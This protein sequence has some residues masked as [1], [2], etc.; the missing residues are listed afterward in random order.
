[1]LPDA[2]A[3]A[4]A[5]VEDAAVLQLCLDW[6]SLRDRSSK[7][8]RIAIIYVDAVKLQIESTT[9]SSHLRCTQCPSS[10]EGGGRVT[11]AVVSATPERDDVDKEA[12]D[13]YC[14]AVIETIQTNYAVKFMQLVDA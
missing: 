2:A 14:C 12:L 1:M 8:D 6:Q 13:V 10:N 9:K 5:A 7:Q 3:A 4:A 11:G